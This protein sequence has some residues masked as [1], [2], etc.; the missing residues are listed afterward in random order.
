MR[1][2]EGLAGP[3]RGR[4]LA[5]QE[6]T[7]HSDHLASQCRRLVTATIGAIAAAFS[8]V[9]GC[10]SNI[11]SRLCGYDM[12]G[13][14]PG[15]TATAAMP[16]LPAPTASVRVIRSESPLGVNL[17]A[18]AGLPC[19]RDAESLPEHRRA[20]PEISIRPLL[21]WLF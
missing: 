18:R 20:R 14:G 13:R 12:C 8:G 16:K 3:D 21:I 5:Q 15:A 10:A 9:S 19:G 2:G 1:R 11:A 17:G 6:A 7:V 4:R